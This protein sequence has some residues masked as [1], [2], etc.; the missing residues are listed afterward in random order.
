MPRWLLHKTWRDI[1]RRPLRSLL[2]VAGVLIGVAG[3][4]AILTTAQGFTRVQANIAQHAALADITIATREAPPSIARIVAR[5]PNVVAAEVRLFHFA[6]G[7]AVERAFTFAMVGVF[8]FEQQR[9]N[10]IELLEG[11]WPRIPNE[12]VVEPAAG[13]HIGETVSV[14]APDGRPYTFTIVGL[15]RQPISI[16]ATLSGVPD[17]FVPASA[18]ERLLD[19]TGGN[20]LYVRLTANADRQRAAD[21]IGRLLTARAIVHGAPTIRP[22]GTYP[23]KRELDALLLLLMLFAVLGLAL[24]GFLVTATINAIVIESANEIAIL[25]TLGATRIQVLTWVLL[26]AALYGG[27]G[28]LLGL[29]VGSAGGFVLMR[30]IGS[31]LNITPPFTLEPIALLGG[32]AVG[33]ATALFSGLAPAWHATAIPVRLALG[34]YGLAEERALPRLERWLHPLRTRA[35]LVVMALRNTLRRRLRTLITI[36]AIGAGVTG[37]LG[38]LSTEASVNQTIETVFSMY[39]ADAWL[40]TRTHS[41]AQLARSLERVPHVEQAEAWLLRDCWAAYIEARCWGMPPS[42]TLYHPRLQAGRWLDPADP[43]GVVI[44]ADLATERQLAPGENMVVAIGDQRLTLHVRGIVHDNSIFLGSTI[45][46]KVFLPHATLTRLIQRERYANIFALRVR[47]NDIST[48]EQVLAE[49]ERR[50]ADVRPVGEPAAAEREAAERQSRILALALRAMLL[51]VGLIGGLGIL[52]TLTLGIIERRREIGIL[53]ALGS[54]M[55]EFLLI[56]GSEAIA[57]ALVGWGIGL[58]LGILLGRSFVA[59]ME[60][61]LFAIPFLFVPS[62]ALWSLLFALGLSLCAAIVPALLAARVPPA[63]ALRYE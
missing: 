12:A 23:G 39:T 33:S 13:L 41:T 42:T 47:P 6:R 34:T 16:A 48:V 50:F 54:T 46:A 9:I 40:I 31:L 3:V 4:V 15:A 29:L 30:Q 61:V 17:L 32:I 11:R 60:R 21:A 53:R 35:P 55:R 57:Y 19:T 20:R 56:F 52:N 37:F 10:R 18:L 5:L 8:D 24:G 14:R 62:F 45:T 1:V 58:V 49:I 59:T 36:G 2:T 44:S 63:E 27:L 7:Q 28:T 38:A 43:L 22:P 51:L 25:K 26:L